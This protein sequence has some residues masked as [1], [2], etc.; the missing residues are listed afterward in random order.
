MYNERLNQKRDKLNRQKPP[1]FMRQYKN[2]RASED[3]QDCMDG[4]KIMNKKLK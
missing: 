3:N 4:R 1:Q 2:V